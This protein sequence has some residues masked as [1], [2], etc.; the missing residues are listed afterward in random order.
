MQSHELACSYTSWHAGP[1]ACMLFPDQANMKF[2]EL[3]CSSMSLYAV[4]FLVWAAHKN[5]ALLVSKWQFPMVSKLPRPL[6][7]GCF[8]SSC[9][10]GKVWECVN[11]IINC[12]WIDKR[13]HLQASLGQH[14]SLLSLLRCSLLHIQIL[15]GRT[16]KS[17]ALTVWSDGLGLRNKA[18]VSL[19]SWVLI[20]RITL[21]IYTECLSRHS[22]WW[23]LKACFGVS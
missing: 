2:H 21:I 7:W 16:W 12:S 18:A 4:P 13:Q 17:K 6:A 19:F 1:W 23:L 5:F 8:G 3:A 22:A 9:L 14:H 20:R 10:F 11:R 15:S